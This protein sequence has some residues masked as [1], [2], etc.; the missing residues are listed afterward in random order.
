MKTYDYI[1]CKE[2]IIHGYHL[3]KGFRIQIFEK[4]TSKGLYQILVSSRTN[5]T[6][7]VV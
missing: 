7:L 5:K 1:C 4:V 3:I 2:F 6:L